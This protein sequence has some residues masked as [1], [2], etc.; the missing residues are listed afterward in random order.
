MVPKP[1]HTTLAAS[2]LGGTP[3]TTLMAPSVA[4]CAVSTFR[5]HSKVLL[6]C[7]GGKRARSE[8]TRGGWVTV[9]IP[10]WNRGPSRAL[11]HPLN[12]H[13]RCPTRE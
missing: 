3:Q 2:Q 1:V 9:W 11:Q 10:K 5:R 7:D 6:G 13:E 8:V 12:L 4:A